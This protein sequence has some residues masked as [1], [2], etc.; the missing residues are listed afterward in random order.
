MK[1]KVGFCSLVFALVVILAGSPASALDPIPQQPGFS[2]YIQP[3]VGYMSIESNTVAKILSF[4]LSNQRIDS[5]DDE[6]D[7]ESTAIFT[8]PFKLAYT[9]ANGRT[10][11][12]LG[13]EVGDLL[14]FD[15]AQQLAVKQDIGSLGVFQAGLLFSGNV[16]VWRDPYVTDRNRDD[17]GR[18]NL[19]GQ[20]VWDKFLGSNLELEYVYRKVDITNESSGNSIAELTNVERDRLDRNGAVHQASIG[21]LLEFGDHHKLRP[22]ISMNYDD[23]DGEA[24]ANTGY[25]LQLTYLYCPGSR[26]AWWSTATSGRPTTTS[27]TRSSAK[28]ART[29]STAPP[30]RSITPTPGA[31]PCW[32]ANR[33]VSSSPAPTGRPTPTSISTT[34]RSHSA[35]SAWHSSGNDPLRPSAPL[36]VA[37]PL[38]PVPADPALEASFAVHHRQARERLFDHRS[39]H[40]Q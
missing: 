9:F 31:G 35:W 23:L 14:S 34:S 17:T 37:I 38:Q 8:V 29:T 11:V 28:P 24:M 7:S 1:F 3:G 25:N 22:Q 12:F 39:L 26:S 19:G 33:R 21:Y 40:A 18:Q 36:S 10:Q 30:P 32:A 20:L 2:G 5:L 27:A 4:D 15:T 6:P 16:K 13:T